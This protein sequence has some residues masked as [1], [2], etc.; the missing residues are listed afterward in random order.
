M[1]SMA[2]QGTSTVYLGDKEFCLW[3]KGQATRVEY[4]EVTSISREIIRKAKA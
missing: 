1:T 3:K 4:E 2:E